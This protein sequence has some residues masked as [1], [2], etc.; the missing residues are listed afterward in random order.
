MDLTASIVP[1]STQWNAEDFLSGER[2][3]VITGVRAGSSEQPVNIDLAGSDRAYRPSKSMRR[4]LVAAWGPDADTY[5]GR[6]LTLYRDPEVTFGRD[7]TG[8]IKISAL[9]HIDKRMTVALT[10]TRGKRAPHTV[11]PLPTA[12]PALTADQI[13]AATDVAELQALW[14]QHPDQRQAIE[15]RVAEIKATEAGDQ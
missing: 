7:K 3:F 11:D 8:G 12:A 6:S 14:K 13:A 1:D 4:V 2:T 15:A 9:S 5:V 10:V